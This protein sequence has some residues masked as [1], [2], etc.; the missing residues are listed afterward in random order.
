[1]QRKVASGV[2]MKRW[3]QVR[4]GSGAAHEGACLRGSAVT[5]TMKKDVTATLDRVERG[6]LNET[7]L[8]HAETVPRGGSGWLCP[9]SIARLAGAS[10]A[11]RDVHVYMGTCS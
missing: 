6:A 10:C 4:T 11:L 3:F 9:G 5:K 1:M 2:G 7:G 8:R